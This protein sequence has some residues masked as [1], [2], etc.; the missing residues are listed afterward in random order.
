MT[1]AHRARAALLRAFADAHVERGLTTQDMGNALGKSAQ[2]VERMLLGAK[3]LTLDAMSDL[4][5]AMGAEIEY[6]PRDRRP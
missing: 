5:L 2:W 3:D 1:D 4:A 6:T